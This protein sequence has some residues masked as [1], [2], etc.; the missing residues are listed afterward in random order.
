MH[1]LMLACAPPAAV[2]LAA[3]I[4]PRSFRPSGVL[5]QPANTRPPAPLPRPQVYQ[6]SPTGNRQVNM[7]FKSD[8]FGEAAL[9]SSARRNATVEARTPLTALVIN[10]ATF[11]ALLGPLQARRPAASCCCSCVATTLVM[12]LLAVAVHSPAL[13]GP[14]QAGRCA[15]WLLLGCAITI[16]QCL[17]A[18]SRLQSV[19]PVVQRCDRCGAYRWVVLTIRQQLTLSCCPRRRTLWRRTRTPRP[20]RPA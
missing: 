4:L 19:L 20:A 5:G 8:F 9:L 6:S 12:C 1:M 18:V 3:A 11:T 2:I 16:P 7:L 17:L 10:R 14:L 15:G 13:L